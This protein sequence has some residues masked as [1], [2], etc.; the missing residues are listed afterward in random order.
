M[1]EEQLKAFL[2]KVKC[3]STLQDKLRA[4]KSPEDVV[5]IASEYGHDFSRDKIR[6]LS[7]EELEVVLG[8]GTDSEVC[9]IC[10]SAIAPN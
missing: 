2:S 3:D 5:S 6:E 9:G 8:G 7:E 10:L 1:S 4:A